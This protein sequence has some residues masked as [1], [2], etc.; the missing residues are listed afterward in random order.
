MTGDRD[1]GDASFDP[2][3]WGRGADGDAAPT[4]PPPP[5]PPTRPAAEDSVDPTSFD[6]RAW[7]TRSDAPLPPPPPSASDAAPS[8]TDRGPRR[9]LPALASGAAILAI[10]IGT[11]IATRQ[12][13]A[14]PA[15]APAI[16]ATAP[17]PEAITGTASRRVLVIDGA[18]ALEPTLAGMGLKPAAA[19]EIAGAAVSAVSGGGEVR[20][21]VDLVEQPGSVTLTR[22]EATRGDGA[23]VILT[24]GTEGYTREMLAAK[25]TTIVKSARGEMDATDFYSSAVAAGITDSLV[26][27]IAKAFSFDFDFQREVAPGDVFEAAWEQSMNPQGEAVGPPRLVFAS[28][29]TATKSKQLYAFLAPGDTEIGWYDGNG[30]STVR[31][32][33]RTPVDGARISSKFGFRIH[34]VLGYQKLHKGTDFA[35]PT[36]TPIYASG[37]AVVQWAAM[38]GANGNLTVLRHD[39]GWLTLYLHQS[40]YAPGIA[41]GVRV[42]QGQLIGYIGTTGR[43]TGPHLHYEVHIDGQAV[44]PM[45]IDTGT[46]KQ[47]SGQGL[48]AFR[49][50]RD[51]IDTVRSQAQ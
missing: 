50:E 10:G 47:L 35:A 11:A 14:P 8:A 17:P 12:P 42:S 34:P 9:M 20:L 21:T 37:N 32:L 5:V 19:R 4:K 1:D 44:D 27:E 31:A 46:G 16:V 3:S 15:A 6:P 51:R 25:L 39:N 43:S 30:R 13:A 23:G 24:A 22:L 26:S 2:R 29:T 36:G 40:A 18:A 41:P 7:T 33:M 48:D 49:K 38:K 28:L 45:S